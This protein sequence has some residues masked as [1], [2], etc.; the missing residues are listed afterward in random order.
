MFIRSASLIGRICSI[1]AFLFW[2]IAGMA[3]NN[4]EQELLEKANLG[5]AEA[6]YKIGNAFDKKKEFTKAFEFFPKQ[7][8]KGMWVQNML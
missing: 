6:Q 7:L 3:Q 1:I 5:D 8:H 2:S 4:D